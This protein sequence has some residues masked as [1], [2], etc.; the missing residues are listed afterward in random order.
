MYSCDLYT[1]AP[2]ATANTTA[3]NTAQGK[4]NTK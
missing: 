2:N 1:D 3:K 4:S